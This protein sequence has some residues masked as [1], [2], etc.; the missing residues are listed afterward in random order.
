MPE[1]RAHLYHLG[2]QPPPLQPARCFLQ[3]PAAADSSLPAET[4]P[5]GTER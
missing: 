5:D 1:Q 4:P 2:V 3:D